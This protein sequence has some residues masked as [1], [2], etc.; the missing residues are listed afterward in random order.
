MVDSWRGP[1]GIHGA[2]GRALTADADWESDAYAAARNQ[3]SAI[4]SLMFTLKHGYDFGEVARRGLPAVYAELLEKAL[5]YNIGVT[6]RLREAAA[7]AM[8]DSAAPAA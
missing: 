7:A 8:A 3:R 4:E 6:I 2:K 5:A 1:A